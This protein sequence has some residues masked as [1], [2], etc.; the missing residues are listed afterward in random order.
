MKKLLTALLLIACSASFTHAVEH[1]VAKLHS[2]E[3]IHVE[4][5]FDVVREALRTH[6]ANVTI[7]FDDK[8][9]HL[10]DVRKQPLVLKN[11][12]SLHQEVQDFIESGGNVTV[13]SK[14]ISREPDLL[15]KHMVT[16][17]GL[18]HEDETSKLDKTKK[19]SL[20]YYYK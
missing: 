11:G 2:A 3:P 9:I 19:V 8:A 5:T 14:C 18:S 13:C 16:G 7:I 4:A 12:K 6:Q 10:L 20:D 17:V 1:V 15:P